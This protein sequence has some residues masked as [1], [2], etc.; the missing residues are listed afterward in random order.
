MFS[1]SKLSSLLFGI[2][3]LLLALSCSLVAHAQSD[4][5]PTP[6][7]LS[8]ITQFS[9]IPK[10][11]QKQTSSSLPLY[12]LFLSFNDTFKTYSGKARITFEHAHPH[13][14]TVIHL[15]LPHPI[16]WDTQS[17][18]QIFLLK[19]VKIQGQNYPQH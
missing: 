17:N 15:Q 13:P 12:Q 18:E 1:I 4:P 11:A 19:E 5:L 10:G 7:S 8:E 16:S 3:T 2:H 9:L 14:Q 6:L